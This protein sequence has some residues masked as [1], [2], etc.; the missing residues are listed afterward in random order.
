MS[1]APIAF[2][3]RL[4]DAD[5]SLWLAALARAGPDMRFVSLRAMPTQASQAEIAVVANPDPADLKRLPALRWMQSL[6][7]GVDRLVAELGADAP[8]IARLV[9]P[10]LARVMAESVLAWTLYLLRDMPAYARHQ[11]ERRWI[12]APYRAPANTRVSLLGLGA[13]GSAAAQRLIEA[14]FQ[15]AGW[16]R[17]PKAL[18]GVATVCGLE[19]LPALLAR[20]DI[21][22]CLTPLTPATR[23]L[24]NRRTLALLPEGA[25]LVNFSRGPIVVAADLIAALDSGRLSH[26]VLDVF[27]EEPLPPQSPLWAHPG[28]TVL[29][30]IAAPTN[31]DTAA[32]IVADTIRRYRADGSLPPTVDRRRGY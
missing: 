5:E 2:V 18:D 29:P 8:P 26:A 21:A 14:G 11:R 9:D 13:L 24:I 7:A 15:V 20:T 6:W 22:I 30:H 17:S 31:R 27:D 3:S 25:A 32:A 10:E 1:A 4:A 19:G 28:V 12:Q 23:G 16:S